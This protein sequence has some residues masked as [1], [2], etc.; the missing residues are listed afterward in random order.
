MIDI[1]SSI[2]ELE[3]ISVSVIEQ[4]INW[5]AWLLPHL[6][7]PLSFKGYRNQE[8]TVQLMVFKS[9]PDRGVFLYYK[10][11]SSD[12]QFLPMGGQHVMDLASDP[13]PLLQPSFVVPRLPESKRLESMV[14][15]TPRLG[16]WSR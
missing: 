12:L 2:G 8:A 3:K 4:V 7:H 13:D 10:E 14:E 15:N 1:I 11:R 5:K 6:R 9:K 16:L